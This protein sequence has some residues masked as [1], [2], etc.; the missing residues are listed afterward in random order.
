[1]WY[2]GIIDEMVLRAKLPHGTSKQMREVH[3]RTFSIMNNSIM[4]T[5]FERLP[6]EDLEDFARRYAANCTDPTLAAYV[7][8]R[9]PGIEDDIRRSYEEVI[10]KLT[11]LLDSIDDER[12]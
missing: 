7:I 6:K 8:E 4:A 5:V 1:M 10:Q 12:Y 9:V 11:P 3:R 2:Y